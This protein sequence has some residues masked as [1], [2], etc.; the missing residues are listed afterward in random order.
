MTKKRALNQ[1]EAF[2]QRIVEGSFR[3]LF[4]SA[5]LSDKLGQ[6]LADA[7]ED[8][9]DNGRLP[10]KLIVTLS[11]S[12][13]PKSSRT[14][15]SNTEIATELLAT[16]HKLGHTLNLRVPHDLTIELHVDPAL[17]SGMVRVRYPQEPEP[18]QQTQ[19]QE[20]PF[21]PKYEQQAINE[22]DAYL[23]IGGHRHVP[24]DKP[25]L[26]L[27]RQL[28]NDVVLD[29]PT[30]SRKHAQIRW[31]FGRFVLYALSNRSRT[32]VNGKEVTE[33]ALEPGDVIVLSQLQIIYG[34][35]HTRSQ[36]PLKKQ[37]GEEGVTR[38]FPK[39]DFDE[40]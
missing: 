7:L 37:N 12:D 30:I 8:V 17:D 35:G 1:F 28:S 11:E 15:R 26:T 14:A 40:S 39:V 16:L 29:D 22:L 3:R 24:L 19:V 25:L 4:G 9:A 27:G 38:P 21:L 23:I 36:T 2:A 10:A 31:R 33:Y 5:S 32:A 34:E 13:I 20:R 6:Q 18:E